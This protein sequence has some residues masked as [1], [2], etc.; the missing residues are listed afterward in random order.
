MS[1]P[2]DPTS[3]IPAAAGSSK[4]VSFTPVN[5]EGTFKGRA[6]HF[7]KSGAAKEAGKCALHV[8]ASMVSV[9]ALSYFVTTGITLAFSAVVNAAAGN[10]PGA[11]ACLTLAAACGVTAK[12][13]YHVVHNQ[14]FQVFH[15]AGN[16]AGLY[17][18]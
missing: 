11:I 16:A 12:A 8:G 2:L 13:L 6:V 14:F 17:K 1:I 3:R 18:A 15:H 5:L 9:F 10:V 7:F 4:D